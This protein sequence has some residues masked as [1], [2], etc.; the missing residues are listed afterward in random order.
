LPED[1]LEVVKPPVCLM[2]GTAD[3]WEPYEQGKEYQKFESVTEFIPLQGAGHCPMDE[4]P[5]LVNPKIVDFV[6]RTAAAQ[7]S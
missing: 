2:W 5:E 3:P 1:L 4:Q 7:Q 6:L